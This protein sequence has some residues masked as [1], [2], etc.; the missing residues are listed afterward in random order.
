MSAK[1]ALHARWSFIFVAAALIAFVALL[2]SG[3][4]WVTRAGS[5]REATAVAPT[6]T[7]LSAERATAS[8]VAGT[9]SAVARTSTV[10]AAQAATAATASTVPTRQPQGTV[11]TPTVETPV[12]ATASYRGACLFQGD[13]LRDE[14]EIS[15]F[16]PSSAEIAQRF[17]DFPEFRN[18]CKDGVTKY[19]ATTG[20]GGALRM[21]KSLLGIDDFPAQDE[22]MLYIMLTADAAKQFKADMVNR[23]VG[24]LFI[25]RSDQADQMIELRMGMNLS[26]WDYHVYAQ[27][28]TYNSGVYSG[29]RMMRV[30]SG[31]NADAA[32]SRPLGAIAVHIGALAVPL[33]NLQDIEGIRI[34]DVSEEYDLNI[35][36]LMLSTVQTRNLPDDE[37]RRFKMLCPPQDGVEVDINSV[38]RSQ[39]LRDLVNFEQDYFGRQPRQGACINLADGELPD[40]VLDDANVNLPPLV[41]W[42]DVYE[43]RPREREST[44][45][46]RPTITIRFTENISTP[47]RIYLMLAGRN[48]CNPNMSSSAREQL[49]RMANIEV[50]F[51]DHSPYEK[52]LAAGIDVRQGRSGIPSQECDRIFET[53]GSGS[54]GP[55]LVATEG[56]DTNQQEAALWL[57]VLRI[58]IPQEA[59]GERITAIIITDAT[60]PEA[61]GEQNADIDSVDYNDPYLT[62]YGITFEWTDD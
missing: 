58:D 57:D 62:L 4:A 60:R 3:L 47:T 41:L 9:A 26:P 48:L 55:P 51:S 42:Q 15:G 7:S 38:S 53:R 11:T 45:R 1:S 20:E 10:V 16:E 59:R 27:T 12:S 43:T 54:P 14:I 50:Q 8:A 35:F 2:F 40:F 17:F 39:A 46:S 52:L 6:L 31:Y 19:I 29:T 56:D 30:W 37:T 21:P 33:M 61:R 25:E 23:L 34:E 36:G 49:D 18:W 28:V 5:N 13:S 24:N 22:A 44:D 32:N